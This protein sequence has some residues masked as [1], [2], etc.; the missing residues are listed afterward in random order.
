MCLS[1][2][3]GLIQFQIRLELLC[4]HIIF[5]SYEISLQL[6][7]LFLISGTIK[8][9]T[10]FIVCFECNYLIVAIYT[11]KIFLGYTNESKFLMV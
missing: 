4:I 1:I 9:A 2:S 11:T 10:F 8:M 7:F 3:V 5:S 6:E